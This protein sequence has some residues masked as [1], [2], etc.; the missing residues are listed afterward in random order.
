MMDREPD[1]RRDLAPVTGHRNEMGGE[2]FTIV[3]K[4]YGVQ[5]WTGKRGV[6]S[7]VEDRNVPFGRDK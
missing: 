1:Q 7:T 5:W 3:R 2:T 4:E 6:I